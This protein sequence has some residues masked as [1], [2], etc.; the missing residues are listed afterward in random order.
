MC[1]A[2]RL[3]WCVWLVWPLAGAAACICWPASTV[4]MLTVESRQAGCHA[5]VA[6]NGYII[7]C[8]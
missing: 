8:M 4:V 5:C 7:T 6:C 2:V 1:V 3:P